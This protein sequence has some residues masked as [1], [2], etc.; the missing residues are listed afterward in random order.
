MTTSR[1]KR[2]GWS[3]ESWGRWVDITATQHGGGRGEM[4]WTLFWDM[5]SGGRTK[6]KP[7][8]EIYIEAPKEEAKVIFYNRFGRNPERV[9]CTCCGQDYSISEEESLEEATR[10]HRGVAR[11]ED[12][13]DM[14][15]LVERIAKGKKSVEEYAAL[16]NV[17]IVPTTEIKPEE[18]VGDVPAEG[19]VWV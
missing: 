15:N 6:V 1:T 13:S 4:A 17:L 16:P 14:A 9:T 7:Y 18:R 8:E 2:V 12:D 5:H 3:I 10:F 11:E 19:Y